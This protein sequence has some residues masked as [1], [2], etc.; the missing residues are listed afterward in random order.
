MKKIIIALDGPA[1][2]G[3]T[4]TAREVAKKLNYIYIDTGAMYRAT[5]LAYIR[6]GKELEGFDFDSLMSNIKIE[7]EP[8]ES[9]QRT[10]LNGEDVSKEIRTAE[11]TKL[12]SPVAAVGIVREKLVDQQRELGKQG[13]VVMDGR[14]IGTVVFPNADLKLYMHASIEARA[15]RRTKEL[16]AAGSQVTVE[17][18]AKLI[19]DRD[20]FDS[21]REIS[22]LRKADDAQVIDTS[23]ITIEEQ[24]NLVIDLANK[25]INS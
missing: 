25:I 4:T 12:A 20:D 10:L 1:G 21:S 24:T 23:N 13:G 6:S 5:T 8:S 9:G 19:S 22:P 17:E 18:I 14:D 2:S 16:I 3:K 11:V 15:E 7:L